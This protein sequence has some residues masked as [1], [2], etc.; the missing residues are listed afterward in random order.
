MATVRT[1]NKLHRT[2]IE[3]G[4]VSL[5]VFGNDAG[6]A[7]LFQANAVGF[8]RPKAI[9]FKH[10]VL[11]PGAYIDNRKL[12][13]HHA[14][15]QTVVM[16]MIMRAR[17]LKSEYD[18]IASVATGGI[19]H[20]AVI[21]WQLG[22]PHVIVKKQEKAGHGLGGLIDGDSKILNGKKVLLIEDMSST[23]ESSLKAMEILRNAGAEVTHTLLI[24][25]WELP[26]FRR[27]IENHAVH[28]MC[29]GTMILGYA[30]KRRLVDP[31]YESLIRH[32]LQHPEDERWAHQGGWVLPDGEQ[33][34]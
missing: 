29:T 16:Q 28:A 6:V 5:K 3:E 20:G 15:W 34:K 31:A 23:F 26:D 4:E 33:K 27:N 1:R 21:G 14:A 32:W 19:V 13:S 12:P 9:R 17:A 10:G 25:T 30:A 8:N 22:V 11:S 24:N 18:V 2:E 7:S